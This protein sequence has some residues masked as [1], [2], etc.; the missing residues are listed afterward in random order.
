MY[1]VLKDYNETTKLAMNENKIY[2]LKKI[3]FDENEIYKKL[4]SITNENVVKIYEIALIENEF[5]AVQEFVQGITLEDYLNKNGCL[6]D[7]KIKDITLQICNGLEA[8]HA[9][10][11]VHRDINP[12]NIM[13]TENEKIVIIDFGISR[14]KKFQQGKDTQ[15]LG[16]MGFAPPEQYGFSQT[17]FQ[18][19]IYSLGVL[20]N[21][22][23]TKKLPTEKVA[24]GA[25]S[26]V[27]LKCTQMDMNNRYKNVTELAEDISKKNRIKTLIRKIPGFR[28]DVWWHKVIAVI[29]YI[30]VMV[31]VAVPSYSESEN[32]IKNEI[33][34]DV[35]MILLSVIPAFIFLNFGNW[36]EKCS[37]TKNK[38]KA[39]KILV[40]FLIVGM[41]Y[42]V[43]AI[44]VS[45]MEN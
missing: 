5:Y 16:T 35:A 1:E 40:Q 45:L 33:L 32:W 3:N 17:N 39:S 8:I 4:I 7:D 42:F 2:V 41:C 25:F 6:D 43:A 18:S 19:D 10:G 37:L 27:I 44:L 34:F 29:Y 28:K 13:I 9:V 15:L 31:L 20:M 22:L 23:K 36:L 38:T 26:E 12:N 11:I 14:I 30:M 21:Y 24:D